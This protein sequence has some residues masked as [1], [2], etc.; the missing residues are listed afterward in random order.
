MRIAISLV[1]ALVFAASNAWAG[2]HHHGSYSHSSYSVGL[3]FAYP[4]PYWGGYYPGY[5]PAYGPSPSPAWGPSYLN[6]G[7]G[8]GSHGSSYGLSFSIPLY[9][10]PRYAPQPPPPPAPLPAG[11]TV[12]QQVSPNCLQVRE[13]QTEIVVGGKS[14]PAY[15][16]ACLQPDGSWKPISGPVQAD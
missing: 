14:V 3:N 11:R 10:G 9:F 7:Y 15:G 5:G 13:Y 12:V 16:N 2:G 4:P 6:L 1:F 8:Y